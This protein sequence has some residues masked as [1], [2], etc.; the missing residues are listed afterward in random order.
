MAIKQKN[1]YKI[2]SI[3][4][5][6]DEGTGRRA[7]VHFMTGVNIAS[8]TLGATPKGTMAGVLNASS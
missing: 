2:M 1:I 7:R 6:V 3:L 4:C 5:S 8:K